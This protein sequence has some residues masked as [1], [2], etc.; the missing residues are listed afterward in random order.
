MEIV[1]IH[2]QNGFM[3]Q[4]FVSHISGKDTDFMTPLQKS[5]YHIIKNSFPAAYVRIEVGKY[6]T[7][8]HNKNHLMQ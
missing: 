5:L 2:T 4:V 8:F 3:P 7:D 6:K 1:D